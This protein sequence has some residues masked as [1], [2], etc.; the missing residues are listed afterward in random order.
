MQSW[1]SG[2][3]S[4][5]TNL[6]NTSSGTSIMLQNSGKQW[7]NRKLSKLFYVYP[8]KVICRE[9][10]C[11]SS[12]CGCLSHYIALTD[13]NNE[14]KKNTALW[15]INNIT[16]LIAHAKKSGYRKVTITPLQAYEIQSSPDLR[17]PS[18][19]AVLHFHCPPPTQ[20]AALGQVCKFVHTTLK[21]SSCWTTMIR[22]SHLTI[23]KFGSKVLLKKLGHLSPRRGPW[24][25]WIWLRGLVSLKLASRCLKDNGTNKQRQQLDK[26]LRGRLLAMK[27]FWSR[28][29][30][31]CP[32]SLKYV[33]SSCHLQ[34]LVHCRRHY[35]TMEIMI[36]QM[37][38]PQFK[39]ECLLLNSH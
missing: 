11:S 13:C 17:C 30:R 6:G 22:S 32:A 25:F 39:K 29:Q 24:Q 35:W 8:I 18:A 28:R 9:W 1:R 5:M 26:N 33:T 12:C 36:R 34:G 15:N 21:V 38:Y 27:R 2:I 16:V 10:S 7:Y 20:Y 19:C 37:T 23:L 31:L 4:S 14:H 3:Q